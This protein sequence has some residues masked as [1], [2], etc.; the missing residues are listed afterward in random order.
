[1]NITYKFELNYRPNKDG[2]HT[3]FLRVTANRKHRKIKTTVAVKPDEFDKDAKWGKWIASKNLYHKEYNTKLKKV[4]RDAEETAD[5]LD[6]TGVAT[7]V[8][9][10]NLLHNPMPDEGW[11]LGSFAQKVIND[12]ASNS[13]GYQRNLKSRLT[14]FV[15][16][17]GK[18]LPL[19][20]INL[21]VLNR[22]KR[23]LQAQGTMTGT[24]HTYFNRIKRMMLEALKLEYI[25]KDP[26]AHFDM[27]SD[28]P[29][30]RLKLSD[31]QVDAIEA[32]E[33]GGKRIDAK[34]RRY[35]QG[36]WLFRAKY[37]YLFAYH[38]GGIR[39]RDVLQIRWS[40]IVGEKGSERL[41]YQMSKTGEQMSTRINKRAR[42]II[43]LFRVEH[44]K[45]HDYLF[46]VLSNEAKYAH[47][48]TYEQKKKMTRELAV[49]LFNDISSVQVLINREL[50]TLAEKAGITD[51]LTFHTA[52]HSFA[53]KA[54]RKMKES[55][56]I[57][58]DDIR[59]ALG[60]QRLDTTQRYLNGFDKESLD[61]AMDAIFGDD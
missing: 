14:V 50:K 39:S 55:K 15:E 8:E 46:G 54:R 45:P 34:G 47:Y 5:K 41:E 59:Q 1:M 20:A 22:F 19:R 60:H 3:I 61:T 26:F 24:Q 21:D 49:R 9:V 56:N 10:I 44:S 23:H 33:V 18:E 7:P 17:A 12:A 2:R 57:S 4:L 32:V 42:E 16:F 48:V 40:N 31:G 37:L 25:Q 29:A 6:A 38:M 53:D 58:I 35:D 11:T 28:K 27:P 30:P 36:I 13:V 51:R 43:E 52:R